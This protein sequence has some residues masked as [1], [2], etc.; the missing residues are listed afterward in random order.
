[1][2]N[3]EVHYALHQADW[4]N[5]QLTGTQGISDHNNALKMGY[6]AQTL[7][8]PDWLL[9]LLDDLHFPASLLPEVFSPGDVIGQISLKMAKEF[10]FSPELKIC[11]GT[12]DSTAAI[13]ASGASN[14]GDAV[15]SLGSTLVM[16]IITETPVFDLQSGVYSQPYG[17]LWLVGGSSNSGGEVLKQFFTSEELSSLTE[18]LDNKR[19]QHQFSM[20]NLNYYPLSAPGERFPVQD[21]NYE[22]RLL[23]RP[24]KDIDFFQALLEGMA[25]IETIA[26]K[27]LVD[28]GAPYPKLVKSMGGG[29][30]N[31]SW[32]YIREQKLGVSV[33][34]ADLEQAAA[35]TALLAQATW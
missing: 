13:Y 32:R 14:I 5:G 31:S 19:E 15:T 12:T 9:H 30:L 33:K 26:Y 34:S 10:G 29:A 16:K 4:L 21:S 24:E 6:D 20:L 17:N 8:W 2:V 28:L 35:G 22:P 7:C 11:A 18:E 23:P 3:D 27:K 1:V 25:D